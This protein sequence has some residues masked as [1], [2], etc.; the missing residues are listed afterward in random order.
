MTTDDAAVGMAT[1]SGVCA[2]V[3]VHGGESGDGEPL[4]EVGGGGE[5]ADTRRRGEGELEGGGVA[6]VKVDTL[7]G[8]GE[9]EETMTRE[10]GEL[11]DATSTS[12]TASGRSDEDVSESHSR[13]SI[14]LCSRLGPTSGELEAVFMSTNSLSAISSVSIAT[15]SIATVSI[16]VSMTTGASAVLQLLSIHNGLLA[17]PLW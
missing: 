15:T 5:G 13:V 3:S 9:G 11:V 16:A 1:K 2:H 10:E 12:E 8:R 6:A 4:I 7:Q 17:L 14:P